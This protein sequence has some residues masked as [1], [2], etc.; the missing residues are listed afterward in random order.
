MAT[1]RPCPECQG[2]GRVHEKK[3]SV[4]GGATRIKRDEKVKVKIPAGVDNESTIRLAE[5][6]EAGVYGGTSGDLY[7]HIKVAPSKKFVRNGYDVHSEIHLHLLQAILGDEIDVE[8][9]S[10]KVKL[11]I[12]SGTQIGK[13][14]RLKEYGIEKLR[15]SGKGDHYVKVLVDIPTRLSRKEKDL[16]LQLAQEGKVFPKGKEGFLNKLMG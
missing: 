9:L 1:S 5:K 4:C 3:C 13:I 14:F 11:K 12:P 8:I 6:G 2:E 16:Y 10:G 15:G 7:I